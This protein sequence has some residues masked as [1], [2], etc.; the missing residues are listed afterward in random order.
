MKE[1]EKNYIECRLF[2]IGDRNV[3]KTSFI[4]RLLSVPSTSL[5]RN[6]QA[7][8]EFNKILYELIKENEKFEAELMSVNINDNK[9]NSTTNDNFNV[10]KKL[11]RT[12]SFEKYSFSKTKNNFDF[13]RKYLEYNPNNLEGKQ[14]KF[15]MKSFIK[16]QILSSRY[17]RP[18][19]PEHP[20]ILFNINK[21][22]IILKPYYIFPAEELP[23]YYASTEDDTTDFV[24]EG[25]HKISL[26]GIN[27]DIYKKINSKKTIV[28][29]EKL[30]GYK[31][32]VYNFFIFIYD[33]SDFNSFDN[34]ML[35]FNKINSKFDVTNN[36]ENSI[37]CLI[38]NKKD[39]KINFEKEQE[40]KYNDFIKENNN[41]YTYEISTKPFF[42]FDKFF[43]DFFFETLH[44]YHDK[45][46]NEYNFKHNFEKI[47]LNK[48]N[49]S[50]AIRE[51][52][53][54][55]RD[56]PGPGYDLNI[57]GYNTVRELKEA[58]NDKKKRFNKKIFS[59]KQGPII[60]KSKSLKDLMEKEKRKIT[61]FFILSKGGVLNKSPKGYS[62]GNIKGKLDLVQTRKNM[63][64][65]RNKDLKDTIEGDCTLYNYNQEYKS[66]NEEYFNNVIQR[67]QEIY[68]SRNNENQS[69]YE[70]NLEIN[71]NNLKAI[72][73][74]KEERKN[75]LITKLKLFKSSST[76]NLLVSSLTDENKNEKDFNKQRFCEVVYPK[77][78]SHMEHYTKKRDYLSKNK[79]YSETPGPNAY[80]IRTNILDPNKGPFILERRKM[81]E[82]PRDDPSY[83][84]FKDEFEIIA[85]KAEKYRTKEKFYKPRFK[86]IVR[87]KDPG[88]YPDQEIW[89]KWEKN[90]LNLEKSGRIKDFIEYRK[91]K[92]NE[93]NENLI[94]IN[95]EKD[96]IREISRAILLKKGYE[97]P[98]LLKDINYSL[99]EESSPKYTIKGKII[100][101][102][103]NYEDYGK[104]LFDNEENM[105]AIKLEQLN[106]PLPDLNY[107]RP[108]LPNISF[109]KAERF[110]KNK[111][112][113]G[114]IYLFKDGIFAPKTQEDFFLKE[115]FSGKAQRTFFGGKKD[116]TPSP[117]EYK[118][119]SSFELIADQGK[120]IS[121]N[122]KRIKMREMKEVQDKNS[123]KKSNELNK[124]FNDENNNLE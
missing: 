25:T 60:C 67:K 23:D 88:P 89:K 34:L 18:P 73:A 22:K 32:S 61:P 50:K 59:N 77:N 3:G 58:F 65:E 35:Y 55:T 37:A 43:F 123:F 117:A 90:K 30:I 28:E 94:K 97:D 93:H 100:H 107:V 110:K 5:V 11:N 38:G 57:Y 14:T 99:V 27:N 56:N 87:E 8:I 12:K 81:I 9:F 116:I 111:E 68:T 103:V 115:P 64:L 66:R 17:K 75:F 31:V 44:Q 36:E 26:K 80:D 24:L 108:K 7:E 39:K 101:K 41:I 20:S 16:T 52:I 79:K 42:N 54:P 49:F 45:L 92:L 48:S 70:K 112:Y 40:T 119:K 1:F 29:F 33:L 51:I 4:E 47:V 72:E 78:K 114:S 19:V 53:D 118:I 74:K 63:F 2:I 120:K 82:Y 71:K 84:D 83:P 102:N 62:F 104:L 98:A 95:E 96:Q 6:Y 106:R 76:P 15:L 121:E 13:K 109:N 105:N 69:K 46:F 85:E 124:Q 10:I 86:E 91:Q 122:R 113:E 21:S